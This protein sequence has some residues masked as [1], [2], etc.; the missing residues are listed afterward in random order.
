MISLTG[1]QPRVRARFL[2]DRRRV[3]ARDISCRYVAY[4]RARNP[5][6][7]SVEQFQN[8]SSRHAER[9]GMC[10]WSPIKKKMHIRCI[11]ACTHA[12]TSICSPRI[13]KFALCINVCECVRLLY[14]SN[15]LGLYIQ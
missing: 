14:V 8:G 10:I 1:A 6:R 12:Y 7:S 15:G 3:I 2:D 5:T 11:S 4:L 13:Y 9:R